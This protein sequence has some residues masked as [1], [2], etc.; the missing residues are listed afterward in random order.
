MGSKWVGKEIP[1]VQIG[2]VYFDSAGEWLLLEILE[3]DDA[4]EP[5]RLKLLAKSPDKAELHDLIMDDED[6]NWHKRYLLVHADPHKPCT[7]KT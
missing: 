6:W 7:I 1:V 3:T 5:T 4:G 2:Q